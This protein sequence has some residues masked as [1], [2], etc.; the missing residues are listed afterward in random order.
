MQTALA[1][2]LAW[3]GQHD[4]ALSVLRSIEATGLPLPAALL[5]NAW[6]ALGD[7][8]RA[9]SLLQTAQ[10]NQSPY[11]R[12]AFVDPRLAQLRGDPAFDRLGHASG[13]GVARPRE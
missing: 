4:E 12:Y 13:S 3:A 6:V 11:M 1:S 9:I 7:H 2:A 5:A 8:E 10:K